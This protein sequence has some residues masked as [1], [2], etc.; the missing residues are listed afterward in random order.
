MPIF[1]GI[2]GSHPFD[3]LSHFV[4]FGFHTSGL[5]LVWTGRIP[6]V[7]AFRHVVLEEGFDAPEA[8][9]LEGVGHLVR[10]QAPVVVYG[11]MQ[12][13]AVSEGDAHRLSR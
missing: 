13:D 5:L 9:V 10:E 6:G 7:E 12:V 8:F 1:G 3:F 4:E 11:F 2:G